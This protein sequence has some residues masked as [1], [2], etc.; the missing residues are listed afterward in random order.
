MLEILAQIASGLGEI[1]SCAII[2]RDVKADNVFIASRDPLQL[3]IGDLGLSHVLSNADASSS[4]SLGQEGPKAWMAPEAL[5]G[6]ATSG[7]YDSGAR[8]LISKRGDV[9]MFGGLMHEVLTGP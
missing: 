5:S 8:T 4:A 6:H 3:K 1:H 2:H 9:Y 7:P